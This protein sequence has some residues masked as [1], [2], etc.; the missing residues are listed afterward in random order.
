MFV[1]STSRFQEIIQRKGVN[2]V[3]TRIKM[4]KADFERIHRSFL[5]E[6]LLEFDGFTK[7][8]INHLIKQKESTLLYPLFFRH[9]FYDMEKIGYLLF[10]D[11]GRVE[12]C[13]RSSDGRPETLLNF[14]KSTIFHYLEQVISSIPENSEGGAKVLFFQGS[15]GM[16]IKERLYFGAWKED[17]DL[18]IKEP[19]KK[20]KSTYS[21]PVISSRHT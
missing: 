6:Y 17:V 16:T 7:T 21:M 1:L 19:I 14:S 13:M 9:S 20:V 10:V 5:K 3:V 8:E 15:N 2:E 11:D 4:N 18:W 12:F